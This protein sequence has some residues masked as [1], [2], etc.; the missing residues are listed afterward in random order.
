MDKKAFIRTF[1]C[2]M[3]EADSEVM[4]RFLE[5]EG[6]ADFSLRLVVLFGKGRSS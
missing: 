4:E 2:Q 3:D 1:G 6:V 5:K